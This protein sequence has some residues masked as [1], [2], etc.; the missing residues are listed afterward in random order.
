[1]SLQRSGNP[2]DAFRHL[3]D[4]MKAQQN[5]DCQSEDQLSYVRHASIV[6]E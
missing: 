5:R 6:S 2:C 4:A 1:M 3:R